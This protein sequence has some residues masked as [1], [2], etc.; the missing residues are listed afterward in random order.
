LTYRKTYQWTSYG[1]CFIHKIVHKIGKKCKKK[2]VTNKE[3]LEEI[4]KANVMY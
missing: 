1:Y 3:I 4:A 2:I